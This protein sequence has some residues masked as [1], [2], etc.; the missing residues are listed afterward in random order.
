MRITAD[1]LPDE[2]GKV[3]KVFYA[4]MHP[5]GLTMEELKSSPHRYLRNIYDYFKKKEE[6]ENGNIVL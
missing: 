2:G 6:A 5:E 4:A 1:M 3:I